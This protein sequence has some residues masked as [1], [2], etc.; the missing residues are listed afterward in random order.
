MIGFLSLVSHLSLVSLA[1]LVV[2][3]VAVPSLGHYNGNR[4]SASQPGL[5]LRF[6]RVKV[7]P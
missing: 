7:P 1:S 3:W 6:S 4:S 2:L 5:R